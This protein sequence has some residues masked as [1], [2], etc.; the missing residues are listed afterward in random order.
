[1]LDHRPLR[2]YTINNNSLLSTREKVLEPVQGSVTVCV[3]SLN[4]S[5]TLQCLE[6]CDVISVVYSVVLLVHQLVYTLTA[7]VMCVLIN[8]SSASGKSRDTL[9]NW[10]ELMRAIADIVLSIIVPLNCLLPSITQ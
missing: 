3:N 8:I 9:I 5:S 10:D 1:M 2:C 4:R 6:C 7:Q